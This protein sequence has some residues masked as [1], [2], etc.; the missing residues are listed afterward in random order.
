MSTQATP[1]DAE[2]ILKL[3]DLR[4]E[5]EMRKA[6]NWWLTGFWPENVDE[7][8]KV[9]M[10]LGTQENN[11]M[12]QVAG[13]WEMAASLVLHGALNEDLFLEGSFSGE[14]FF[15][16]AKVNPFLA[17]LREKFQ[18]P[19]MMGN[20]EKVINR[21]EKGRN[22]FKMVADRVAMLRENRKKEQSKKEAA[23]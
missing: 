9:G 12:R 10:A 14:M 18:N 17:E 11:W 8:T 2:L 20:I 16:Y 21:S 19:N 5:A 22:T 7:F 4:R 23:A 3:Y 1:A 15:I 13:Y 6:R